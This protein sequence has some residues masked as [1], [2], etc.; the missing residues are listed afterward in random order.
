MYNY[1]KVEATFVLTIIFI[2][3]LATYKNYIITAKYQDKNSIVSDA[4]L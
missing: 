3:I 2:K 4:V 1:L